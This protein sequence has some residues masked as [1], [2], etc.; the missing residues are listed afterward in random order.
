MGGFHR[1]RAGRERFFNLIQT[2]EDGG[3]GRAYWGSLIFLAQLLVKR[4]YLGRYI[5][6]NL[7]PLR[8]DLFFEIVDPGIE[9]GVPFPRSLGSGGFQRV[10]PFGQCTD[11][12]LKRF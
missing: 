9:T 7:L 3:I 5:E 11:V 8:L 1:A 4:F 2:S 10:S 12:L 6:D